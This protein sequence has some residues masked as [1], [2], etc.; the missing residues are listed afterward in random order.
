MQ[1]YDDDDHRQ[2]SYDEIQRIHIANNHAGY[3]EMLKLVQR[4]VFISKDQHQDLLETTESMIRAVCLTCSTC[5]ISGVGAL[6]MLNPFR[7]DP[8]SSDARSGKS[9]V[10]SWKTESSPSGISSGEILSAVPDEKS[11][12]SWTDADVLL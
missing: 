6:D 10:T 1:M 12:K 2:I 11:L 7:R 8:A 4:Q 3:E 5:Q 9:A